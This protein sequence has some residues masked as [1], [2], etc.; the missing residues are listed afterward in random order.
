MNG[1]PPAAFVSAAGFRQHSPPPSPPL[2]ENAKLLK[3]KQLVK[4]SGF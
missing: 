2:V 3:A 4:M 1:V